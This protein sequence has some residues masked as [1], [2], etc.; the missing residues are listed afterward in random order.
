MVGDRD[1][2][3]GVGQTQRNRA[4]QADRAAGHERAAASLGLAARH[5]IVKVR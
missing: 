2:E 1:V 4:A 5:V 3:A